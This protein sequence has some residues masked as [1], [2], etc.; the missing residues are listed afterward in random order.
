M[1]LSSHVMSEVERLAARVAIVN[2]GSMVAF[3]RVDALR[4]RT[5][6]TVVL[7]F[8][9]PVDP[10]PLV[11][12]PG[13]ALV[14]AAGGTVEGTVRGSQHRVLEVAVAMGVEAVRSPERTLDDLFLDLVNGD[15][16]NG[17]RAGGA[18]P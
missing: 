8:A 15:P 4:S 6:A 17:G 18:T 10:A 2:R 16:A 12:V 13:F 9:A 14:H 5:A 3:D 7:E 1:L 11:A